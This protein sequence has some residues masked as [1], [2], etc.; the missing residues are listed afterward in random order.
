VE[1]AIAFEIARQKEIVLDNGVVVQETRLWDPA[2][3]R[4][5]SMRGKEDAHDY[6][7]FPDPDLLPLV[8]DDA[9]VE[10]TRQNL[11]ELPE[12]KKARF[13]DVYGLPAYDAG[14]LS[15]SR[16][17]ADY[18]EACVNR[19][20]NPKP[21]SNWIMG[22]LQGLLN[23][24]GKSIV[25]TP[26]SHAALAELLEL[27]DQGVISNK[28]AKTVFEEMAATGEP[29]RAIVDK[30]GLVQVSDVSAIEKIVA[31]LLDGN[32]NEVAAFKNGKTKLMGFFVGQ[33][34][35]ET[36]GK[37]DPKVVNQLLKKKLR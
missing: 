5:F 24:L 15:A 3:N 34:M 14:V 17:L 6:R 18:F 2:K 11:P 8:I 25:E 33:V 29:A 26:V 20:P 21:V 22:P 32:P 10:T 1:K 30:K 35:R 31:A 23:T 19:F 16:E 28:I 12:Q 13:M 9:W 37:A 7:Y 27:E 36:K 4:T